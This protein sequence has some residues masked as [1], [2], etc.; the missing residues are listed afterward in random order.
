MFRCGDT[1][2][3]KDRPGATPHLW[4]VVTE[5]HPETGEVVI[6]NVTTLR[7]HSNQTVVLRKGDHPF[8]LHDSV[9]SYQDARIRKV[10]ELSRAIDF[11]RAGKCDPCSEA[12]LVRVQQGVCQDSTPNYIREFCAERWGREC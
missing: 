11:G 7:A 12:L 8:I 2:D 6:V 4:I 10:G 1:I 9:V 3:M 5:P